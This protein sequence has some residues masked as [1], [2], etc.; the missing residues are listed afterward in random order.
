M[1]SLGI[2]GGGTMGL[3]IARGAIRARLVAPA[4]VTVAEIHEERHAPF[5]ELGCR[6]TTVTPHAFAQGCTVLA[7]KP[8]QAAS[9]MEAA[10]RPDHPVL[11]ISVMAGV[12]SDAL[13]GAL[14]P[15]VRIVRAMP[16]TPC[17]LGEGMT[18]IARGAGATESDERVAENLFASLGRTLLVR[19]SEIDAI[20]AV[21]GSGPAYIYLVAELMEQA[22]RALGLGEAD[23]RRLVLQTV[24]G[25]GRLM[26]E[27]GADPAELRRA[28]T[29]P[30]G[31]T[32]AAIGVLEAR[33][34]PSAFIDAIVAARE[35]AAALSQ[36]SGAA[37][38]AGQAD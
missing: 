2:V 26:R 17:L 3:A 20:T 10:G 24:I 15:Q 11:L 12:S 35:R 25:A 22:A 36:E 37:L 16:N 32:A 34:V 13:R 21:S 30:A 27:S 38:R 23:A 31:T 14:G 9:V 19:E 33:G 29:T 6:V 1:E 18:G 7:V 8:F 5:R 28:V 4:R